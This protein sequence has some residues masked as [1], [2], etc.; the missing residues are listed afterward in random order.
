MRTTCSK[1]ET[2]FDTRMTPPKA[3]GSRH[4]N[5]RHKGRGSANQSGRAVS[6]SRRFAVWRRGLQAARSCATIKSEAQAGAAARFMGGGL[7]MY[8]DEYV[9]LYRGG[10]FWINNAECKQ[11]KI[12]DRYAAQRW[13]CRLFADKAFRAIVAR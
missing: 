9:S 8:Q 13:R 12:I 1:V 6:E 11:R 5:T 4:P 3:A 10:G 7:M 2:A